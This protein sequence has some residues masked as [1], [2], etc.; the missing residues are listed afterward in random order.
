MLY[1]V[2]LTRF[3]TVSRMS[4]D[5]DDDYAYIISRWKNGFDGVDK[6]LTIGGFNKLNS[7]Y[8]FYFFSKTLNWKNK[9]YKYKPIT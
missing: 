7:K 1:S 5:F 6:H 3:I 4:K 2:V 8:I 9:S